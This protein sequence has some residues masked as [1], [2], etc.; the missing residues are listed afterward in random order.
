MRINRVLDIPVRRT[1]RYTLTSS[2][3]GK[4]SGVAVSAGLQYTVMNKSR[5]RSPKRHGQT[6]DD[7]DW[8]RKSFSMHT[9]LVGCIVAFGRQ[10]TQS[11]RECQVE[12]WPEI[13]HEGAGRCVR[14]KLVQCQA[15]GAQDAK[16]R[17]FP[18]LRSV[19]DSQERTPRMLH[20]S[21]LTQGLHGC[22]WHS[23]TVILPV[24]HSP[25]P[26]NWLY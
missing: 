13:R 8:T 19:H 2:L 23:S 14:R 3:T 12:R 25:S 18:C 16:V 24:V 20:T 10:R 21:P 7:P 1:D 9:C 17:S 6:R 5:E 22:G 4:R 26:I 15:P 11:R